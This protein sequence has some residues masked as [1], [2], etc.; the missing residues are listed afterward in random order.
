MA[1]SSLHQA[2][3]QF[4][5][6]PGFTAIVTLTLGL[7][8]GA[9]STIFSLFDAVL[10]RPFPYP[11]AARLVRIRTVQPSVS[12]AD[13]EASIYDVEDWRRDSRSFAGMAAYVTFSSILDTSDGNA[14]SVRLTFA[15]PQLFDALG[16]RPAVGQLYRAQD[17]VLGGGVHKV[18]LS[19][20]MWQD[21]FGASPHAL[22]QTLRLRGQSYQVIGVMPPGFQYPDRTELWVPLMARY[23]G[24]AD[25]FWKRRDMRLHAVL[26]KLKP[27]VSMEQAASDLGTVA[28]RLARQYPETNRGI[29]T[30]LVNLREAETGQLRPYLFLVA[31]AVSL[32]LLIGC[33]NV[34]NLFVARATAREREFA[35]RKAMG[36]GTG[37][38][39]GLLL[40]ESAIYSLA[41]G[42]LGTAL[43]WLGVRGL[44]ALI[45]VD[46]PQWM[47]FTVDAR[48]LAFAL[49]VAAGT[50]LVFGLAPVAQFLALDVN[51]VLKQGSRG[52]ST[53]N[54]LAALLRRGLVMAEVALS[55][56]LLIGAGLMLRSFA[57]LMQVD[58]GVKS[59]GL[60]V[61]TVGRFVPGLN[62]EQRLVAY[63]DHYKRIRDALAALPGVVAVGAGND[64]PYLNQ[65]EERRPYEIYTRQRNTPDTAWR[66]PAQGADVMPG[67]FA[68]LGVSLLE[69]RDFTE[70]DTVGKPNVIIISQRAA[71]ILFPGRSAVGEQIRWGTNAELDPW[72]TIIGVVGSTQW[73]PAERTP[74]LEVYWSYRQYATPSTHMLV[75]TAGDPEALRPVIERT[76]R[77]TAP[78]FAVE[79]IKSMN[80]MVDETVW[81]RRL[82][83][84]VLT[85]FAA[86]ALLLAGVGLFGV[87]SYLV[88]QRTRELGIRMAIGARPGQILA[89]VL[90]S[91]MSLVFAG[92]LAGVAVSLLLGR[93]AAS[94]LFGVTAT[95]LATYV[96]VILLLVVIGTVACLAP[97]AQAAR[98]D[99]LR[100]LKEE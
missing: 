65:P 22:G 90:R 20:A 43:A 47:T 69:G 44:T 11:E 64:L 13:R 89:I 82:W 30:R 77:S 48:V 75:R 4:S 3:R 34:A 66:G 1:L 95:D 60:L 56:V 28:Q 19:H 81:Q 92:A 91:G 14:R 80:R 57:S 31:A 98:V 51:E 35:V 45:P 5:A 36:C 49:L 78:E 86:L 26:A 62:A 46:L 68:A 15:N 54:T 88:S 83:G 63:A 8:I 41:G 53:G 67:F 17:D 24:Y 6:K 84:F 76:I 16:A 79:R 7:T 55:L 87:M 2:V 39:V 96:A 72:S 50:G 94:L 99:P 59:D 52:S 71:G 21:L 70:A 73:N 38:M 61:A 42:L 100:A 58:T 23:A 93:L 29:E 32:L 25:D 9:A 37:Q 97:A 33:V 27:G 10:L 85:C 18:V 74:G 40:A 12:S